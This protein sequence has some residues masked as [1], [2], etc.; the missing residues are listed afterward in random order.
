MK[1]VLRGNTY[2]L[3][4]NVPRE[5]R[6]VEPR[7]EV[8]LSLKTDSRSEA[9]V[10]SPR[11]WK[12]MLAGWQAMRDG[13]TT[14][15]E[16][17]FKAA[18]EVARSRGFRFLPVE[19]VAELPPEKLLER[20]E[21]AMTP[22]G[23]LNPRL[24]PGTIG[25]APK[26]E[27][28]V[29]RALEI[30]WQITAEKTEGK[31]E[32]QLRRWKNPR[33][34][35]F[36]NFVGVIGDMPLSDITADDMLDFR[37]WWFTKITEEGLTRNSANKDFT[38][39]ASALKEVNSMKRLG[40]SLPLES[41]KAFPGN[42]KADETR[43]PF[44]EQWIR[45]KILAPGALDGLNLE[46]RCILLGMVN[47]GYRPSEAQDLLP[48]HIRLD[49]NVPHITIEPVNRT[50]KTKTSQRTIPLVGVSLEAFRACPNGF[51]RYAGKAGLSATV[52]K[53]LREN[54]LV[55]TPAHTMYG[56]RHSFEDRLLDRDIDERIR[57]D[58]MGHALGRERYGKGA[59]LEKLAGILQLIAL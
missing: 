7:H 50:L 30:Y 15:A 42:G 55:Q 47:T 10:R 4:K 18:Q 34:K 27:V 29:N 58:L 20:I 35:A 49:T 48:E 19:R 8:W 1:V 38:H 32:D 17:R 6:A 21:A 13:D 22:A 56:L 45:E 44:S 24:Y 12:N 9:T 33:T 59:S 53:Y 2:Y 5:F 36:K 25:T 54:K 41:L 11:A 3:R 23:A 39:I 52:N 31:S 46:A 14:D 37:D 40:L 43:D 51:P 28:T 16:A 26:P 57:R